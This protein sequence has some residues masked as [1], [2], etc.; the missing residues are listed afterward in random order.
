MDIPGGLYAGASEP[1]PT[2]GRTITVFSSVDVP[3]ALVYAVVAAVFDNPET[4]K[5]LYPALRHLGQ[6]ERDVPAMAD[7]LGRDLRRGGVVGGHA[8]GSKSRTIRLMTT[9]MSES[10]CPL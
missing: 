7:D 1:A 10:S 2:L 8:A 4:L 5:A 3:E 9:R 6:L